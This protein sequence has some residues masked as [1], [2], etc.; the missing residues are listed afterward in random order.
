MGNIS[1][2]LLW[3]TTVCEGNVSL[4]YAKV[5]VLADDLDSW[6]LCKVVLDGFTYS[7]FVGP[8]DAESRLRWLDN[9]PDGM[10]SSPLPYEQ[11]AKVLFEMGHVRDAREILLGKECLQTVD[12]RTPLFWKFWREWWDIFAG[13]GYRLPYT[14]IWMVVFV[15]VGAVFFWSAAHRGQIVP[16]QPAILASEK[17][18]AILSL[19][20]Y[21]PMRA[22]RTA[23]P[24]EYPEFN[25]LVF[26][27]DVF[28]PFFALH[29]E[30]FWAPASS[31]NNNFLIL[32]FL[33]SFF[34]ILLG[35]V[36]FFAWLF[37]HWRR[38][39]DD[40]ASAAAAGMAIL[41]LEIA[42]AAATGVAHVLFGAENVLWL[43]D[44][45]WLTVWYWFEIAAGWI[46]TSL[47][48]LS[49]TGLL[50]PRMSSGE[51]D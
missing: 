50:R 23:F 8:V 9:R 46:L 31:S 17:Y 33:L 32:L 30:P 18:Q 28:I 14:A 4:A 22:V 25:P 43:V 16:H 5:D 47:F 39:R 41:S 29:Q 27:L 10:Q 44:W 19:K 49:V 51:R 42:V 2:N 34:L 7:R 12:E 13:Y 1:G 38:A 15:T 11:T 37:R 24:D 36:M 26:S 40:G 6:K 48:L 21:T 3:R 35:I 20:E 45:R